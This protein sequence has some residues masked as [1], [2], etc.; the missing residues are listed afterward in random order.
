M[1]LYL[2]QWASSMGQLRG[3]DRDVQKCF[4]HGKDEHTIG[5]KE[6]NGCRVA[7]RMRVP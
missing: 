6:S 7:E 2:P 1:P 5:C 3:S 4:F